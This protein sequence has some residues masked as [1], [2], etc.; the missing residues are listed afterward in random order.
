MT[1]KSRSKPKEDRR[2]MKSLERPSNV[3]SRNIDSMK[4]NDATQTLSRQPHY[5]K[6]SRMEDSSFI[7]RGTPYVHKTR[8]PHFSMSQTKSKLFGR[9]NFCRTNSLHMEV[10]KTSTT[11]F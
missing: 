5:H 4:S 8:L 9:A 6:H 11:L 1:H 10:D 2:R 7:G 3:P